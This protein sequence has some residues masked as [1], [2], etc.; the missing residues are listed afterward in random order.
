[1]TC[2]RITWILAPLFCTESCTSAANDLPDSKV[3]NFLLR[4]QERPEVRDLLQS[5]HT[6]RAIISQRGISSESKQISRSLPFLKNENLPPDVNMDF[7]GFEVK[8]KK[9]MRSKTVSDLLVLLKNVQ[10]NQ[11]VVNT[12]VSVDT[13]EDNKIGNESWRQMGMIDSVHSNISN[14][15]RCTFETDH[16]MVSGVCTYFGSCRVDDE[17]YMYQGG[18]GELSQWGSLPIREENIGCSL[19]VDM[20]QQHFGICNDD[21]HCQA[22]GYIKKE[23]FECLVSLVEEANRAEIKNKMK[24]EKQEKK[25]LPTMCNFLGGLGNAL[26]YTYIK[27]S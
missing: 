8:K 18:C 21:G 10:L 14:G 16:I 9:R 24:R 7:P 26:H 25:F 17:D 15:T 27:F 6:E 12:D 3:L 13:L 5:E 4:H 1:M 19:K 23:S 22:A 20:K 2:L 11:Q